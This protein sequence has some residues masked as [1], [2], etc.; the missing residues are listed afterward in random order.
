MSD[1]RKRPYSSNRFSEELDE[2]HARREAEADRRKNRKTATSGRPGRKS[3]GAGRTSSRQRQG[4]GSARKR[5]TYRS[6]STNRP[7]PR[8]K[9]MTSPG[10]RT[11]KRNLRR[12]FGC[13]GSI[14]V[15][16]LVCF[17]FAKFYQK[18]Q[19]YQEQKNSREGD[20]EDHGGGAA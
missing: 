10:P 4:S 16:A 8:R 18:Y 5:V 7:A 1:N 19:I 14:L 11:R 3:S 9:R 2:I 15:L 12:T 17:C 6:G 13:L 20:P